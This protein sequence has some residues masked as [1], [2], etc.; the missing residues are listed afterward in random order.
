MTGMGLGGRLGGMRLAGADVD[1]RQRRPCGRG[2]GRKSQRD[3]AERNFANAAAT[4]RFHFFRSF[5]TRADAPRF[6]EPRLR[7]T[8]VFYIYVTAIAPFGRLALAEPTASDDAANARAH[9]EAHV[10]GHAANAPIRTFM[11]LV[12]GA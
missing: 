3:D 9:V 7:Y 10:A 6:E 1:R 8:E 5:R 11:R 4:H 2:D 12:R